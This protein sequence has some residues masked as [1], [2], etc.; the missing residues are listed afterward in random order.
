MDRCNWLGTFPYQQEDDR[1]GVKDLESQKER[2]QLNE[3]N[4]KPAIVSS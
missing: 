3:M 1:D 2:F 4:S